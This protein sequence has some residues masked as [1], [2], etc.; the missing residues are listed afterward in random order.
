MEL[1]LQVDGCRLPENDIAKYCC[2]LLTA[3]MKAYGEKARLYG[4]WDDTT[5]RD[6]GKVFAPTMF[7]PEW[8]SRNIRAKLNIL[9]TLIWGEDGIHK[10]G[11]R[12]D[13]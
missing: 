12:V 11:G 6:D 5:E 2:D 7:D 8:D 9:S 1:P 4:V 3:K 10:A 13:A